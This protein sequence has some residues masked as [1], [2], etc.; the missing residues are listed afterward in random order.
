MIPVTKPWLGEEEAAAAREAILS[1]WVTQGPR[2]KAFE[3]EFAAYV[4]ARHAVAVSSCTTALHL[5]LL[6]VGVKP[7]D[8][9]IVPAC[10]F[11]ATANA[12]WHCGAIPVLVDVD[13]RT[14]N[15]DPAKAELAITKRTKAIMPVDQVGLPADWDSF[16]QLAEK[17][18]LALVEDAACAAGSTYKGKMVGNLGDWPACF[19][20]HPRKVLTTGEGGMVTTNDDELAEKLRLLR[21]HGMSVSDSARHQSSRVIFEDYV[22]VGY[23][24]RMT[25]IQAAIGRVQLKKLPEMLKRRRSLA[26]RYNSELGKLGSV[27]TPHVPEG[28]EHN[29]QSY[30]VELKANAKLSRDELMQALLDRGISTRRGIMSIH[31]EPAYRELCWKSVFPQSEAITDQ[32]IILPLFHGLLEQEE[33]EI[34]SAI[35]QLLTEGL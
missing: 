22:L 27:E 29:Y 11:I 31:R 20:F 8:E 5:A 10:T 23:N 17:H 4:G 13:R 16:R 1:G 2:V 32:C 18:G 30:M 25:D 14:F 33:N 28:C 7:G 15:L 35:L 9:V 19:S 34:N 21:H 24:Y 26:S 12:V 3:E 6:A